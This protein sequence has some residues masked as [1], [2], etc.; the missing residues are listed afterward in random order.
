MLG[1]GRRLYATRRIVLRLLAQQ[2]ARRLIIGDKV[3]I[4]APH[5][6]DETFGT[7]TL[8]ATAMNRDC[9]TAV[10]PRSVHIVF[11]TSGTASHRG[12]CAIDESELSTA[13]ESTAIRV[14][15]A[16]GVQENNL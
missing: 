15:A 2:V 13:R 14:I 10:R 12:C 9:T 6:D 16:L 4:V 7:G 5:P 11:L 8:V 3:L 1:L